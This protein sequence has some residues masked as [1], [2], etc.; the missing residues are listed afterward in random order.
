MSHSGKNDPET[1]PSA[2]QSKHSQ[3]DD[4][5]ERP[6]VKSL[7]EKAKGGMSEPH[8]SVVTGGHVPGGGA[9]KPLEHDTPLKPERSEEK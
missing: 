4:V 2:D 8:G 3:G 7:I 5:R 6:E 9:A 1:R